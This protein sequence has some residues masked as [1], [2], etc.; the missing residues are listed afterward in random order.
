MINRKW[1]V[2]IVECSD[3]TLYT[4]VTTDLKRRVHEH[5]TSKKGAKYTASRR[6]IK[7]VAHRPVTSQSEALKL[8]AS[9]KKQRK[10]K[11]IEFLM[12]EK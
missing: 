4:G 11:K 6:P 5:N 2:Y 3:G 7:L 12:E 8:E 9:V 10:H 1:Y